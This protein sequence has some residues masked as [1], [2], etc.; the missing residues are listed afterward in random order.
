MDTREIVEQRG[1]SP[2]KLV[3]YAP[4]GRKKQITS[5]YDKADGAA[6]KL[7]VM[8]KAVAVRSKESKNFKYQLTNIK[9]KMTFSKQQVDVNSKAKL[10]KALENSSGKSVKKK[11]TFAYPVYFVSEDYHILEDRTDGEAAL[12]IEP[13]NI[14]KHNEPKLTS[15]SRASNR[16]ACCIKN[17]KIPFV[18]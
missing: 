8:T 2:L 14:M 15:K 12:R 5:F 9:K 17:S 1:E 4:G 6:S 3:T 16:S 13:N 18:R 11:E 10:N 7:D